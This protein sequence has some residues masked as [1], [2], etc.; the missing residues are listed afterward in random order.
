M[1]TPG[2]LTLL[3]VPALAVAL[4]AR[5]SSLWIALIGALALGVLQ[6]EL[7]FLSSTK[8]WWPEWAKEGLTDAVPFVVIVITLFVS[9]GRSRCAARTS[10]RGCRR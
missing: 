7:L 8:D 10:A 6:S 4:I 5:L 3:V 1:L 9:A 2:N